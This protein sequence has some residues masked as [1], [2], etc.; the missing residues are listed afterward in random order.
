ME[1]VDKASD[2]MQHLLN[3]LLEI[4]RIGRIVN[5][6]ESLRP[7][8]I[9]EETLALFEK[10]INDKRIRVELQPDL[11]TVMA[12]K[13]RVMELFQ[14]LIGNAIK[15]MGNSH[16]KRISVAVTQ[17]DTTPTF[18]LQDTG[19]GIEPEFKEKKFELFERL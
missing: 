11:P 8:D 3:D 12:D 10:R 14:N 1:T 4:S 5:D 18:Y 6:T 13:V 9:I 16:E 19:S 15:F 17:I 2:Q 7:N